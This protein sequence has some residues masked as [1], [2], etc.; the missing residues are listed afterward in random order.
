MKYCAKCKVNVAGSREKCP[1]CQHNLTV[2]DK[3]PNE[4]SFPFIERK[5]RAFSL[6]WKIFSLVSF[7]VVVASMVVNAQFPQSGNWWRFVVCGVIC[8][9]A[10]IGIAIKKRKNI[11]KNVFYETSI[12][13]LLVVFWDYFTGWHNWSLEFA[14]PII[15]AVSM[16]VMALLAKILRICAEEH[17]V[18][19]WVLIIFGIIPQF[20]LVKNILIVR[21]P[22]LICVGI[23]GILFFVLLVFEGK[24]MWQELKKRLHI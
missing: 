1:L 16:L 11:L 12:I 22:S 5:R 18:Y 23:S 7:V 21:L 10:C 3:E 20:F 2:I 15:F 14:V 13:A 19:L 17:L 6:F 24:K 9:W 8:A 4:E